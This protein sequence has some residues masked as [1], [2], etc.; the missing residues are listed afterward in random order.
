MV[1]HDLRNPLGSIIMGATL[2]SHND[3]LDDRSMRVISRI[4]NSARRMERLVG[5]LLDLTR[6]RLGSEIPLVRGAADIGEICKTVI[7]ELEGSHPTAVLRFASTGDLRGRWDIGRL[8]QVMSNLVGNALQHGD[9][10]KPIRVVAKG[11]SEH[12][13][14]EVHNEGPAIPERAL[15]DI[16]EPAVRN[17]QDDPGKASS[18]LGMGL[19]IAKEVAAAHQGQIAVSSS[20]EGGTTFT[21]RLPRDAGTRS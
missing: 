19:F 20:K 9:A 12:V 7:A 4:Q 3:G 10:G 13:V 2:L 8:T 14:V 5:D 18:G 11:E 17:V 16:F 6:T 21:L 15:R 1:S